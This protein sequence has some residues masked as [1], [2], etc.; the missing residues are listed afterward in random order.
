MACHSATLSYR[1]RMTTKSDVA[2]LA[3]GLWQAAEISGLSRRTLENHIRM[4][5]LRARKVGR[6]TL[7]MMRD[8]EKFLSHDQPSPPVESARESDC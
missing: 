7:I 8:L 2:V 6:R 5:R 1:A 3:V 4:K